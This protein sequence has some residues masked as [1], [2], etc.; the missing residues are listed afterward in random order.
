[1][2]VVVFVVYVGDNVGSVGGGG[3]FTATPPLG[4]PNGFT[5]GSDVAA[6][7]VAVVVAAGAVVVAA[8]C[9]AAAPALPSETASPMAAPA[10]RAATPANA[11]RRRKWELKG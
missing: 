4:A 7:G 8:A 9:F 10:A 11:V 1:M 5:F 6:A 2:G 3:P